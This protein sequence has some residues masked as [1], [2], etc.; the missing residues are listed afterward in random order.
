[1]RNASPSPDPVKLQVSFDVDQISRALC[2]KF[3]GPHGNLFHTTGVH[4]G[5]VQTDA[6]ATV[7]LEVTVYARLDTLIAVS[8]NSA[9]LS[10]LPRQLDRKP[11]P[12]SPFHSNDAS[13]DFGPF[14]ETDRK[15]D[16]TR[17]LTIVTLTSKNAFEVVQTFGTWNVSLILSATFSRLD[18]TTETRVFEFDPEY[19][20]GN[21]TRP[22]S[23]D[24]RPQ[25]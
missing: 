17:E 8:I 24:P 12:P 13:V 19:Q 4:A 7:Q 10:T 22:P 11:F 18:G 2:W 23:P 9:V 20:V 21:G 15:R 16:E 14:D 1:M 3:E 25:R 6:G 5:A